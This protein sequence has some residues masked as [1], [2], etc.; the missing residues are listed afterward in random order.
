MQQRNLNTLFDIVPNLQA[1]LLDTTQLEDLC[2]TQQSLTM[3]RISHWLK[4]QAKLRLAGGELGISRQLTGMADELEYLSS[5][6]T[7]FLEKGEIE[8]WGT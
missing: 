8:R 6:P 7:M 2:R 5:L 4:G 3:E 1:A